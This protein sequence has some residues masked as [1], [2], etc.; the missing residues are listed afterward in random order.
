MIFPSS[1]KV[2]E[3]RFNVCIVSG[4]RAVKLG[5]ASLDEERPSRLAGASGWL[6]VTLATFL[7]PLSE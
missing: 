6:A 3:Q 1:L 5:V 2:R 4:T 7:D